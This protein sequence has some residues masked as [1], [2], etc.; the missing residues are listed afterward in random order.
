MSNILITKI[1][2]MSKR[3]KW[4][5][6]SNYPFVLNICHNSVR[7]VRYKTEMD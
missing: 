2:C 7:V 1:L 3:T 4:E 6:T 5:V